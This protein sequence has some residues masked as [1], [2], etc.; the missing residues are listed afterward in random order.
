MPHANS[1]RAQLH[2]VDSDSAQ[3]REWSNPI[4]SPTRI[5]TAEALA[6]RSPA[7]TL[8]MSMPSTSSLLVSVVDYAGYQPES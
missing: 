2:G 1:I 4:A 7:E 3:T 8:L 6:A 5:V